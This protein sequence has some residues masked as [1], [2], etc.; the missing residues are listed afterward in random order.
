MLRAPW[1]SRS[2]VSEWGLVL[3][4]MYPNPRS[5]RAGRRS[6]VTPR[7]CGTRTTRAL[8]L[9]SRTPSPRGNRTEPSC[10]WCCSLWDCAIL[11]LVP[12]LFPSSELCLL[13]CSKSIVA[14]Q[15]QVFSNVAEVPRGLPQACGSFVTWNHGSI[16]P[17]SRVPLGSWRSH[18][19]HV[20][21]K[22]CVGIAPINFSTS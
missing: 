20:R 10:R 14:S 15:R 2:S 21:W 12:P 1:A 22:A 7:L 9:G 18:I 16:C 17:H 19:R 4:R 6:G 8:K 3:Q 11:V 13:N 5:G